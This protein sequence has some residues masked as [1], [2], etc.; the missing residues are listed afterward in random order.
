MTKLQPDRVQLKHF[1][2]IRRSCRMLSGGQ[3]P[4]ASSE[5]HTGERPAGTRRHENA[6]SKYRQRS[7]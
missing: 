1:D 3:G 2:V 5:Q 4:A 6:T 7:P